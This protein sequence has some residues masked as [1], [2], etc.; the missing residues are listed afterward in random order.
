[1]VQRNLNASKRSKTIGSF[2]AHSSLAVQTFHNTPELEDVRQRMNACCEVRLFSREETL[3]YISHRVKIAGASKSP[4]AAAASEAIFEITKG[5]MR[6]ID[7][8][9][10]MALRLTDEAK[11][12][13]VSAS[14][15][16]VA[17]AK[18]WM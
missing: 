4:F 18:L 3:A 11:R 1:M 7:T 5:N 17:K 15:V 12:N 13:V 16:A 9:A 6:A 2:R 10:L 8:V 14:D